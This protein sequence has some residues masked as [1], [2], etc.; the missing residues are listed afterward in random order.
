MAT[1]KQHPAWFAAALLGVF[2]AIVATHLA[3]MV[4]GLMECHQYARILLEQAERRAATTTEQVQV[5]PNNVECSDI[6]ETFGKL[7]GQYIAVILA[8]LGGAG[9]AVAASGKEPP[10]S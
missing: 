7:A 3:V 9:V 6:E 2:A 8:L 1:V 10:P 5:V 4:V